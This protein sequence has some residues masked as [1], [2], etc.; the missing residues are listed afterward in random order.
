[1]VFSNKWYDR[2]KFVAQIGLPALGTFWLTVSGL[3]AW[4]NTEEVV[5]TIMALDFLLGTLLGLSTNQYMKNDGNFA[6]D[7]HVVQTED[8]GVQTLLAFNPDSSP[9]S[10]ADKTTVTMKVVKN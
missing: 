10:L 5:G 7:L 9:E 6:G 3:F 1:M 4:P 8:E 2:L